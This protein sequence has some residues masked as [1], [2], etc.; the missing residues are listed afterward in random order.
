MILRAGTKVRILATLLLLTATALGGTPSPPGTKN[1]VGCS[2]ETTEGRPARKECV[3]GVDSCYDCLYS[4]AAGIV[5]CWE[6]ADGLSSYCVPYNPDDGNP[7][8]V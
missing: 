4:D 1:N 3:D 8:E 7:Y 2:L 6:T 5:E